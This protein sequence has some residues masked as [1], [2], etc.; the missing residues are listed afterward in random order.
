MAKRNM[1]FHLDYVREK[2]IN[3]LHKCASGE[4]SL[5][6]SSCG[7]QKYCCAS[8]SQTG[9]AAMLCSWSRTLSDS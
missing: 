3:R 8:A 2:I 7:P 9:A 1:L 4:I 5:T 6:R